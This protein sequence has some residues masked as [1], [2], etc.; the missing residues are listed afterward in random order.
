MGELLAKE[1]AADGIDVRTG[2]SA[3]R[4]QGGAD[5]VRVSLSDGSTVEA[6]RLLVATGRRPRVEGIGLEQV[7]VDFDDH[8]IK[9]DHRC[10]AAPGV[11]AVGDVTG[12]APFTHVAAYQAR[13]MV[14]DVLGREVRADYRAVLRVV[15]TDPEVAAVGLGAE[16]AAEAGIDMA[17]VRVGLDELS[18]TETYGR[19][20][21]GEMGLLAD[22]ERQ[23]L[24]GAWGVGP[25]SGEWIHMAV[26]AIRAEIPLAVLRDTMVQFP[27]FAEAMQVAVEKLPV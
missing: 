19:E 11:W 26:L 5:G 17:E 27:T 25:L 8:G 16:Q 23:V 9:I 6:E 4:A 18:R 10:R 21:Q 14:G 20:L 13:I 22:R 2:V 15:F 1:M 3:D 7:G 12:V 24:V